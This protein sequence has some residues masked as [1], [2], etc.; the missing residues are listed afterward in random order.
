MT[1]WHRIYDHL[2][3][4]LA[5]LGLL[6]KRLHHPEDRALL[7]EAQT[8]AHGIAREVRRDSEGDDMTDI[9]TQELRTLKRRAADQ[10]KT[11]RTAG[12]WAGIAMGL[13]AFSVGLVR[14]H[15]PMAIAGFFATMVASN[16]LPFDAVRGLIPWGKKE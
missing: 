14:S 16:V 3:V 10:P 15:D 9:E 1:L 11:L 12:G 7:A 6:D 13:T 4:L 2:H 5:N 8:A